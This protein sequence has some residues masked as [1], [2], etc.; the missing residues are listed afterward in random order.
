MP[1][2]RSE[3]GVGGRKG[4]GCNKFNCGRE[5]EQVCLV[6]NDLVNSSEDNKK[7]ERA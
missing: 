3:R 5:D 2:G 6:E 1:D 7:A 4:A